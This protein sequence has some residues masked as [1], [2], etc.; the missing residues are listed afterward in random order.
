MRSLLR[1]PRPA[2]KKLTFLYVPDDAEVRQFRVPRVAFYGVASGLVVG[3]GLITF[4]GV[5]YIGALADGR[6]AL[7]LQSENVGLR[8]HLA[9]LEK[10]VDDLHQ[11]LDSGREAQQRLRLLASLEPVHP[12]VIEA[13]V[14]GPVVRDDGG[15]LPADL[16]KDLQLTGARLSQMLRQAKIQHQSFDEVVQVLQQKQALWNRTPSVRPVKYGYLTSRFGRRMDPFTG[17]AAMHRGVDIA[18]RPG[19]PVRATADGTVSAAGPE[20]GYGLMV[21]IDHGG[22]LMTRYGHCSRVLVVPG[23]S[24]KRGDLIARVGS[25]GKATGCHVHY[26]VLQ[27][28]MHQDPM[29]FILPTDVIID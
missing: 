9:T 21:E 3:L 17:Q 29:K 10:N 4:F 28:G 25:S 19:A 22:G 5:R 8:E 12:D 18:A 15:D 2:A 20:G 6:E 23:E 7:R 27:D 1:W 26:E 14:G 13:G 24:V 11:E 16:H